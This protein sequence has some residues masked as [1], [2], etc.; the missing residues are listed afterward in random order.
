MK[1]LTKLGVCAVLGLGI[2]SAGLVVSS[3]ASARKPAKAARVAPPTVK[4][5]AGIQ[6]RP[7]G[8]HWGMTPAQLTRFYDRIID[9]DFAPLYRKAQ[10]GPQTKRLDAAVANSKAAF[11]R[12]KVEFGNLPTGVDSTPLKGEYSYRNG[13]SMMHVNRRGAGTRYFFFIQNKLWK[14]YDEVPLGAKRPLGSTYEQAVKRLATRYGI[15][16]RVTQPDYAIGRNFTE[17]DWQDQRN[18]VRVLDRSGL[19]IVGIVY[20]DRNTLANL[21]SLRTNKPKDV[22]SIDPEV[23]ALMRPPSAPPVPAKDKKDKKKKK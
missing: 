11:R 17:V 14:I 20:E 10:P 22:S 13:E 3:D 1:G 4:N 9:R 19:K 15:V 18:H 2:V 23:E 5:R 6:L 21:A 16:G 8:L 12:S 7:A